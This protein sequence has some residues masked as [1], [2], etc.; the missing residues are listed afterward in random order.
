V[1]VGEATGV[2]EGVS[3][4]STRV[5]D[6]NG[7]L[8]HIPNGEIVRTGNMSQGWA[9]TLLDV[10][11]AYGSD[12]EHAQEVILATAESM[13]QEERWSALFLET[14]EMWGVERLGAD[15]IALRLVIKVVPGEQWGISRDL[16]RRIKSALDAAGIEIPFPQ[17]TVWLRHADDEEPGGGNRP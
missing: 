7:T 15:G 16:R 5:R 2:V 13:A 12:I 17:R 6:V 11:V 1:D 4:R 3:L 14:P 8:W 10:D 9:R